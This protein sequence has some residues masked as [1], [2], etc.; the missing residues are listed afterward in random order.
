MAEKEPGEDRPSLEM[1]SFG[2]GRKR[3][4]AAPSPEPTEETRE[5][6][7]ALEPEP[8]RPEPEPTQVLATVPPAPAAPPL[9]ADETPAAPATGDD[10]AAE[11]DDPPA[12]APRRT[13]PLPVLGGTAASVVSGLVA[14]VLVVGLTW[15]SL[16][17]CDVV[18]G[19]SSCGN[20]GIVLLLAILAVAVVAGGALLRALHVPDGTSISV[21]GM[22]LVS[23]VTLLFLVDLLFHWWMI[24][25]IPVVAMAAYALAH[26]VTTA[27]VEPVETNLHR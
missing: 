18:R 20:P 14:G 16:G 3:K 1:P 9:F 22:G 21:L 27:F 25:V 12:E 4:R 26:W 10:P 7:V 5:V 19:T 6:P 15:A 11:D 2:F 23:V 17:L 24:L 13:L 8:V